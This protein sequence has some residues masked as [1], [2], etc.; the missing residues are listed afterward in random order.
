MSALLVTGGAS[1]GDVPCS[2]DTMRRASK[3]MVE[4]TVTEVKAKFKSNLKERN[5]ILYID[6]KSISEASEAGQVVKKRIAI[7]GKT[8]EMEKEQLLAVPVTKSNSGVDQFEAVKKVIEDWELEPHILG[9]AF[10]TTADNTGKHRGLIVR[11]E[12]WLNRPLLWFPCPHHHY[13]LHPKKVARSIYGATTNPEEIIYKKISNSWGSLLEEGI[14]YENLV[15]FDWEGNS[16]EFLKEQAERNLVVLKTL[17]EAKTFPR[18]DYRQLCELNLVWLGGCA[19]VKDFKMKVL[20][21]HHHARFMM[22]AIHSLKASMLQNQL[23]VLSEEEKEQVSRVAEFVG[24]FHGVWFLSCSLA[25]SAPALQL[26]SIVE[27]KQ[28]SQV[29]PEVAQTVLAS[30]AGHLWPLT[31]KSVVFALTDESL[32]DSERQEL[33]KKLFKTQKP[34][35]FKFGRPEFPPIMDESQYPDSAWQ[36]GETPKLE[37]FIGPESW[38]LLDQ[39][40]IK[41]A[42]TEWLQLSPDVWSLFSGYKMLLSFTKN[43]TIV[44]DPAERAVALMSDF[45]DRVQD[46]QQCQ[47]TLIAVAEHRKLFPRDG[48]KESKERQLKKS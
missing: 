19:A 21:A 24:L 40:G 13:E 25:S 38:F 20:G 12:K 34:I 9:C 39:L 6:G 29:N 32:P 44:N 5:L 31:E 2:K 16:S 4:E 1:L 42:D 47:D 30:M 22:Q 48:T 17:Y 15:L 23:D 8:H 43:T 41:D 10:D 36:S 37:T 46:E 18:D 26:S 35:Q 28:Y 3:Q 7:L 45:R 14:N 11:I 33:A 27:M